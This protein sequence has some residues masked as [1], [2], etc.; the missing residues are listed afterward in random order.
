MLKPGQ[1][2]GRHVHFMLLVAVIWMKVRTDE[3]TPIKITNSIDIS[4]CE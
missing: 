3:R 1:P 2:S 4:P